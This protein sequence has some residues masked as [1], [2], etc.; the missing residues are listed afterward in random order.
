MINHAW[1]IVCQKSITDKETNNICL[2]VL[3]QL[4][5]KAPPLPS[6]AKGIIFP[7]HIEIVSLWYRNQ[8]EKGERGKG[9]IRVHTE[10]NLDISTANLNIDLESN[11]RARTRVKMDGLPVPRNALGY[12]YFVIELESKGNWTKVSRVPLEVNIENF[13]SE[14][15]TTK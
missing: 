12:F 8:G 10:N 15:N 4:N 14:D 3:E 13:A 9:R 7:I 5:I 2:D 1:T 6:T 11:H